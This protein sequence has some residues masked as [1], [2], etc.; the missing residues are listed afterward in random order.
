MMAYPNRRILA[1]LFG[2]FALLF[3]YAFAA[4]NTVP[5]SSAGDGDGAVNGYNVAN[6][7]YTLSST[8]PSL[9]D[10][11]AFT[12]TDAGGTAVTSGSVHAALGLDTTGNGS[13]DTWSWTAC[14]YN[15][16]TSRWECDFTGVTARSVKDLIRFRVVAAQ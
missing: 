9:I 14:T 13:V 15:T 3:V 2:L 16:T 1:L 8:D 10:G 7:R 5:S 6:I 4:T 11:V 12:L